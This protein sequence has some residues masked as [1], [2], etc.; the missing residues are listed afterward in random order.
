MAIRSRGNKRQGK[1]RTK[2]IH[3]SRKGQDNG[4]QRR[5][6]KE[7]YNET[8]DQG[9]QRKGMRNT[10]GKGRRGTGFGDRHRTFGLV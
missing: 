9:K 8:E 5:G 3:A 2:G 10:H 7:V 6:Q 1:R 4:K